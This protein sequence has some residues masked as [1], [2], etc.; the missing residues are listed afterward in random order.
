MLAAPTPHPFL[1][2]LGA[3]FRLC[4]PIRAKEVGAELGLEWGAERSRHSG[5]QSLASPSHPALTSQSLQ[6]RAP[7][8]RF[9]GGVGVRG[10]VGSHPDAPPAAR[11]RFWPQGR[12]RRALPEPWAGIAV[13]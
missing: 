9:E 4:S 12:S 11:G 6:P 7:E 8:S 5:R 10:K 1:P 2:G 3:P 13:G